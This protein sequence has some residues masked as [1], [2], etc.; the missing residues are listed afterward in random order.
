MSVDGV[1]WPE[2]ARESKTEDAPP[3]ASEQ[4]EQLAIR[5]QVR[6]DPEDIKYLNVYSILAH[7]RND[8]PVL[9][10]LSD[11]VTS[12]C[13]VAVGFS[14]EAERRIYRIIYNDPWG[15]ESF[16]EDGKNAAKVA[17]QRFG[18][19]QWCVTHHELV[20]VMDEAVV[21]SRQ[22]EEK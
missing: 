20:R 22:Q 5:R 10:M 11:R 14:V 13:V 15:D 3:V 17:A 8:K 16:L 18:D 1:E 6:E 9:L 12:H 4:A 19:H 21:V 7:L 2:T